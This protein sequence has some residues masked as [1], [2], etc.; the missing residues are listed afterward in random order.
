M[1]S[2]KDVAELA[3]VSPASVSYYINKNGYVSKATGLKIEKAIRTLNYTPNQIA[4]SLRTRQNK[5]FVFFCNDIRNPFYS[6]LVYRA[7]Q[8]ATQND[9]TVLFSPVVN[10]EEHMKKLVS[11]QVSGVFASNNHMDVNLMN[12]IAQR[13][14]PIV[15]L[16]D[17]EWPTVSK[18]VSLIKVV[19]ASI[20]EKII[21]HLTKEGAQRICYVSS[22]VSLNQNEIDMKTK[23]F[24]AAA[25]DLK[26]AVI[27]NISATDDAYAMIKEKYATSL[28]FDAFVCTNDAVALGVLR[29]VE[30]LGYHVP[31][32]I[33]IVGCD[34]SNISKFS[35][36]A[37]TSIDIDSETIGRLAIEMLLKKIQGEEVPDVTIHPRLI[38]R[39]SS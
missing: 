23:G 16:R 11:F 19:F 22:C 32:D 28:D 10:N 26:H 31:S 1:A 33:K 5:Q 37:L 13:N 35:R 38:V 2:R 15:L 30:S 34:N 14:I 24:L 12:E 3:G 20:M 39:A 8:L 27:H 18:K 25:K 4:R 17:I 21:A 9:Y 36:P 7:T 29:A 6:Q